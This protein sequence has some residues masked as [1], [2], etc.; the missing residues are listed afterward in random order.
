VALG[1][2]HFFQVGIVADGLD[3]LLQESLVV[4]GHYDHG[5]ELKTFGKVHGANRD[6]TAGFD[7]FVKNLECYAR[8]LDGGTRTIQL[9]C[10]SHKHAKFVRKHMR[11]A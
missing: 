11:K 1:V 6:L 3:A 5:A 2:I 9:C 10:G 7:R 8:F 4:P